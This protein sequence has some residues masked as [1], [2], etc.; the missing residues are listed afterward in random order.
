VKLRLGLVG[1]GNHMYNIMYPAM[2]NM[3]VELVAACDVS[4]ERLDRFAGYYRVPASYTDYRAM[5]AREKLDV[6]VCIIDA[7]H[8]YEVGKA[9]L[10]AGV[11]AFVEKCPCNTAE[12]AEDLATT[13]HASGKYLTAG[14]NRRFVTAY[15]MAHEIINRQEFGP[16]LFYSAKYHANPYRS[17]AYFVF[18]HIVH[19]LDLARY[20]LGELELVHAE[21]LRLDD[22]RVGFTLLLKAA[23]GTMATIQSGSLQCEFFPMERVEINGLGTNVIVDNIKSLQYNRPAPPRDRE[24]TAPMTDKSD[25]QVWNLNHGYGSGY[26]YYGYDLIMETFVD[27]LLAGTRPAYTIDDAVGTMRLLD[28]VRAAVA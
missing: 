5:L 16:K 18:N 19:H 20:F 25:G 4:Q 10:Q 7:D 24:K 23:S 8:H 1:L 13:M 22:R 27:H 11:H 9:C 14:F 26:T 21:K 6:V 12:Q 15:M 17:E 2:K 28:K 3:P